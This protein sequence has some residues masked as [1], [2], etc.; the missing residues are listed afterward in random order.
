M[1][2]TPND[3]LQQALAR[4]RAIRINPDLT[5]PEDPGELG[6]QFARETFERYLK[7]RDRT[8]DTEQD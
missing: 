6:R 8:E 1:T 7:S 3:D 2:S 4:S 5:R